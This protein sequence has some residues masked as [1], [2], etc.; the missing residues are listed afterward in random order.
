MEETIRI[1]SGNN[2]DDNNNNN[3]IRVRSRN[4]RHSAI[5]GKIL[6]IVC[7]SDTHDLHSLIDFP[8]GDILI[9]CGDFTS[10]G[11]I[12]IIRRFSKFLEK[13]DYKH[14]ILVPGNHEIFPDL[15]SAFLPKRCHYLRND[16]IEVEGIH[17]YG[18]RFKPN[19]FFL[20]I[21]RD[22]VA[23]TNWKHI[24]DEI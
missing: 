23:Q 3:V 13:L 12:S 1:E 10:K 17:I 18:G 7:I 21:G 2:N 20:P 24:P 15:I 19:A 5:P 9:H 6:N 11:D 14:K 8:P 4:L 22:S 16:S